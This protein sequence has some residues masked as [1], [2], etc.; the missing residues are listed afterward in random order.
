MVIVNNISHKQN[1]LC[2]SNTEKTQKR[3]AAIISTS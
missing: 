3:L 2:S 1:Q